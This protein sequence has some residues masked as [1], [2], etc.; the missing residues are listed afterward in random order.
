MFFNFRAWLASKVLL[1]D[2]F[3]LVLPDDYA[4][5]KIAYNGQDI[6]QEGEVVIGKDN[7]ITI[8][9]ECEYIGD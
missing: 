8:T 6:N 4:V 5:L 7:P 9:M 3:M 2:A 1:P